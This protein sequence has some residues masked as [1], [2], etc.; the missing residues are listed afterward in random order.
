MPA[1]VRPS[2]IS[3]ITSRSRGPAGP[4]GSCTQRGPRR[5]AT[6]SESRGGPA[7]RDPPERVEEILDVE[8]PVL[9]ERSKFPP[10]TN[11]TDCRRSTCWLGSPSPGPA[12]ARGGHARRVPHRWSVTGTL[13][14]PTDPDMSFPF[15]H[16]SGVRWRVP[17]WQ[18]Q[19]TTSAVRTALRLLTTRQSRPAGLT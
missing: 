12:S 18:R 19:R 6:T 9:S 17:I 15:L 3:A 16:Q 10:E 13:S 7:V 11:S 8:Y 1:L 2:A 4:E 14:H 5:M